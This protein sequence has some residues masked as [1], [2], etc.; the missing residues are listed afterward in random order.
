MTL[1]FFNAANM[2]QA[3]VLLHNFFNSLSSLA[4]EESGKQKTC[5]MKTSGHLIYNF[6]TLS[7]QN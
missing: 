1:T 4:T 6:Y 2:L 5:S 7:V 3:N